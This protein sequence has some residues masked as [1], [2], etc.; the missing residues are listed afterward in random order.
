MKISYK[1]LSE[2]LPVTVQPEALSQIL[3]SIGLEVESMEK[4]ETVKGGLQGVVIGK[5]LEAVQHPNADKLKL[6]RVDVGLAEPLKIVCGAPNVAAGQTVAVATVGTTIYPASGEPLTMKVAKIRGE[7]SHGMICAED[8]LGLGD[9]H[10]GIMI[11]PDNLQ[12]GT[13]AAEYFNVYDDVVFEIGLTPNRMDAMSHLGVARDVCAYLNY[14]NNTNYTIKTPLNGEL[15]T[16]N[17][18][19]NIAVTVENQQACPRYAG[20]TISDVTVKDSPDWLKNRLLAIGQRPINNIVDITNYILHETGQPLHTFDAAAIKGNTVIVKTLAEQTLFTTLDEKERKLSAEDLMIC[21]SEEGMCIAGVFGGMKSGVKEST[22]AVFLESARFDSIYIRRTSL[23][24]ELRTEAAARFEKGVD[25]SNTVN[26]LKRAAAL[27]KEIAGGTIS[28]DVVDVYTNP[29]PK[30]EIELTY[31]YLK[32]LSGK[33]YEPNAVKG[34][35]ENLGFEVKQE[36][37]N[38]ITVTVPYHKTDVSIPADLVEEIVRIDGLDNISIPSTIT[39]APAINQLGQKESVKEK[40]AAFLEGRGLSEIM[41]NSITNSKYYT[42]SVLDHGVKMMNS[43]SSELDVLRPSMLE[44]GLEVISFNINRKNSNLQFFEIGKVYHQKENVYAEYEHI[45]IYLSGNQTHVSWKEKAKAADFF[46]AKGLTSTLLQL[47]GFKKI[48]YQLDEETGKI[49]IKADKKNVGS[50]QIVPA[51]RLKQFDI[52]QPVVFI[53]LYLHQILSQVA[54]AHITYKEISKFPMVERDIAMV[55]DKS[56]T[57]TQV[58]KAVNAARLNKLQDTK[59]F[60]VFES[61]KLGTEKKSLALNF[62]FTD[63]EKTLTDKEIDSMM[64]KLMQQF[65]K[66]LGAEIRKG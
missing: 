64:Q 54:S 15:Q 42:E 28:S 35:L 58:E 20:V 60:D 24:H 43:L 45:A 31:S 13:P 36:N 10:A 22:K 8:E 63:E 40:I 26:V 61:E 21:N 1:W 25:I 48:N 30:I 50:L 39:I 12:A 14:H 4:F 46:Y 29:K 65:E 17:N 53:D 55:V 9:S 3:T 18:Q 38:G 37:D 19:L 23:R 33:I 66:E 2:Y 59:L 51:A 32:K 57:Y 11:L 7:E 16:D 6:T 27:I 44:T 34:I 62:T 52:K 47:F 49:E 41:T 56:I 5:V